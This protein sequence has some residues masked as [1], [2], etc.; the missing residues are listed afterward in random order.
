M[1]LPKSDSFTPSTWRH[2]I[3]RDFVNRV[4]VRTACVTCPK[5]EKV[6]SLKNHAIAENGAVSPSL[7]C[8]E[9]D[10]DFHEFVVLEDWK[11]NV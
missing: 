6:M 2:W 5:C 8:P 9:N 7:V 1:T 4:D 10:C 3:D 11:P